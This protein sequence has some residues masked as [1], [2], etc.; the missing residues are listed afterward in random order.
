VRNFASGEPQLTDAREFY[1]TLL[2]RMRDTQPLPANALAELAQKR[3]LAIEAALQ[4][5][6]ADASRMTRTTAEPSADAEAKSVT[7][8][9]SLAAR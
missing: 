7:V 2:R 1:Q 4:A 5:A 8:H 6:G 3:A 9:L